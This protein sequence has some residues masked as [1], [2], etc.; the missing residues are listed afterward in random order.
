MRVNWT[1][2]KTLTITLNSEKYL[3]KFNE[4]EFIIGTP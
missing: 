3:E 2:L 4:N 1:E